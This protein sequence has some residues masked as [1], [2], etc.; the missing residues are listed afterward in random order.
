MEPRDTRILIGTFGIGLLVVA[1]SGLP[2]L[3]LLAIATGAIVV[4]LQS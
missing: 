2:P 1:L 3:A 4:A